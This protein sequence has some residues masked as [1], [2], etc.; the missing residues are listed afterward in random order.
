MLATCRG[1]LMEDVGGALRGWRRLKSGR[2]LDLGAVVMGVVG[3]G[4]A[5][6]LSK[7][8]IYRLLLWLL[9]IVFFFALFL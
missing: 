2:L 6:V 3:V 4:V 8:C 5:T 9:V 7:V 1:A